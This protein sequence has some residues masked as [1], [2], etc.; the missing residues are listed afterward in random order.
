MNLFNLSEHRILITGS[1]GGLGFHIARGL[2]QHGADV[3]LNGR[4]EGKL[5]KAAAT[6]T[7]EGCSVRVARF[8][9]TS[10]SEVQ[11]A[12]AELRTTGP[13]DVLINNAGIQRRILLD[14]VSLQTW[15]EVIH[16]NLT[17]AMLVSREVAA[18]MIE[19]RRGKIINVCSL[20]S[21]FGRTTTGAYTTAKGG[22]KMLTKAMCADWAQH[23]IQ[24]N[25]IGPGYFITEMTQVLADDPSFDSW[26][27]QRTPAK[28]WGTPDELVGV[29]VFLSS[30][31]SSFING[32][33]IYIDGGM[34]AVV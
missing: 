8:D 21:E 4:N 25:A 29:A 23:N 32:Q 27:K 24:V 17:S 12:V 33:I 30:A 14:Q 15:S 11:K 7:K 16:T 26:V 20:M 18:G 28:R 9:V 2:A 10:E 1:N 19:R 13:I 31:A 3:I 34:S 22:L 5:A 6:L